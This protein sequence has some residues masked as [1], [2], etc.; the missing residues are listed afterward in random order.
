[1]VDFN[2]DARSEP[3]EFDDIICCPNHIFNLGDRIGC[4]YYGMYSEFL[5][6][7]ANQTSALQ[8]F[9]SASACSE[10]LY[11]NNSYCQ[12]HE[13][14]CLTCSIRTRQEYCPQHAKECWERNCSTRISNSEICCW[15][16]KNTCVNYWKGCYQSVAY[17]GSK[18]SI[19]QESNWCCQIR[20]PKSQIYCANCLEKQ[21]VQAEQEQLKS[22]VRERTNV[23][24]T[25]EEVKK[26]AKSELSWTNNVATIITYW[27]GSYWV[28]L[29][30]IDRSPNAS[31][32]VQN[33][34]IFVYPAN[35]SESKW[36]IGNSRIAHS[37]LS[38]AQSEAEWLRN[39]LKASENSITVVHPK[40]GNHVNFSE[41]VRGPYVETDYRTAISYFK[42]LD[43]AWVEKRW[44]L[45]LTELSEYYHVGIYLGNGEL[46]HVSGNNSGADKVSWS[47][48]LAGRTGEL[49]RYHPIIPFKDYKTIIGE[50]IYA[51]DNNYGRG[52]YF[53]LNRNCEHFV[54]SLV[55]G[56][57]YSQQMA[58]FKESGRIVVA[59]AAAGAIGGSVLGWITGLAFAIPT[60][61]ASLALP[62]ILTGVGAIGGATAGSAALYAD[63]QDNVRDTFCLRNKLNNSSQKKS[64]YETRELEERYEASIEQPIKTSDCIIM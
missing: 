8:Y 24:G 20:L 62:T 28:F 2:L 6:S 63:I 25:I 51:K 10:K 36:G 39:A 9:C 42:P 55:Y 14:Q 46:I 19:C 61:G 53:L 18:C 34:E 57:Y 40:A 16:H 4:P 23:P 32:K 17:R 27:N 44:G 41:L 30:I 1:M 3:S 11:T 43:I 29:G 13:K 31:G 33:S 45:G 12:K 54:N 26:F 7:K 50:A 38:E 37:Y 56:I 64:D 60:G 21:R 49:R 58:E 47:T 59:N 15:N 22:L 35:H 52:S 5:A 48:F